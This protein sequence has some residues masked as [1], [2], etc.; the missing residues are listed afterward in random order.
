MKKPLNR[1]SAI[2]LLEQNMQN[3]NLRRHCFAVGKTL[4]AFYDFY[5]QNNLLTGD[6]TKE[7]WEIV[8]ILHDADWEKTTNDPNQHT[9]LLLEWLNDYEVP[10]EML[11]VFRSHNTKHTKL[12]EP[13]T[14]LEWTLECCD[15]LTG[16]IVAVA[17]VMPD[18]KLSDVTLERVL[19]KFKQKEFARAV[20]RS[21]ILQCEEKLHMLIG[22][23]IEI[24]LNAM[25]KNHDLLG[26]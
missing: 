13:E 3:L 24:T 11:N 23:F 21:Q 18:K 7:Q 15:E 16:F 2:Q 10:E 20:E 9:L 8:G 14:L 22:K 5:F 17:L 4:S 12:R 26:L 25:Q 6:L 19:S 1:E